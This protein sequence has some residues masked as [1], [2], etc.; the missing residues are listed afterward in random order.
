VKD[1]DAAMRIPVYLEEGSTAMI[2]T[3]KSVRVQTDE[4]GTYLVISSRL[5]KEG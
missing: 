3:I 2:K 5:P 1:P 4:D